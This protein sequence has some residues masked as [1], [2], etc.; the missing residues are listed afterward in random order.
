MGLTENSG[1]TKGIKKSLQTSFLKAHF[2]IYFV[3]DVS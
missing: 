2:L 1:L 3:N